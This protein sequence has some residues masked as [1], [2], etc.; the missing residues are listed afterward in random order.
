MSAGPD[1]VR[2]RANVDALLIYLRGKPR[3]TLAQIVSDGLLNSGEA[4]D[5]VRFG[6]RHGLILTTRFPEKP[7]AERVVYRL[8]GGGSR[9]AGPD[10]YRLSFDAL[11]AAWGIASVAPEIPV[12]RVRK[13]RAQM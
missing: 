2:T 3:V 13:V 8:A 12:L 7:P 6:M 9:P 11:L 4:S 10:V 5:A 1:K